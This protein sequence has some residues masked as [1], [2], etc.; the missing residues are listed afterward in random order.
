[1]PPQT[2]TERE[3]NQVSDR[4]E[5]NG[6]IEGDRRRFI[7]A[8]RPGAAKRERKLLGGSVGGPREGVDG[9]PLENRQLRQK[10]GRRAE[11]VEPQMTHRPVLAGLAPGSKPDQAGAQQGRRLDIAQG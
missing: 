4:R 7:R 2:T 6:C 1:M 5:D 9:L 8:P 11:A 3:G 10:M